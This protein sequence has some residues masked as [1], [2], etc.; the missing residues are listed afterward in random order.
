M[1][2]A[3]APSSGTSKSCTWQVMIEG[4]TSA[5]KPPP[6]R[7]ILAAFDAAAMTLGS[8]TTIGTM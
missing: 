6:A 7:T 4:S 5:T 2:A 3:P 8:S 1:S